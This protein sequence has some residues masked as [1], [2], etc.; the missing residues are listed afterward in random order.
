MQPLLFILIFSHVCCMAQGMAMC[1]GWSTL[2]SQTEKSQ[3]TVRWIVMKFWT[4]ILCTQRINPT[5]S[6]ES[7]T[8]HV[9]TPKR[10]TFV[11][12]NEIF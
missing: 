12:Q 1:V 5:D 2:L 7:L 8:F 6:H 11:G 10:L 4:D 3:N 9:A